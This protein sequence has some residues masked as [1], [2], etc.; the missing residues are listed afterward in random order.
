MIKRY[1]LIILLAFGLLLLSSCTRSSVEDPDMDGGAGFR[2]QISGTANPSV[3][4]IPETLP[5]VYSDITARVLNNDGSPAVNYT[6][7][8][9]TDSYGYFENYKISDTRTTDGGGNAR[10]RFFIP[11]GTRS[12]DTSID[13]KATVVDDGRNDIPLLSEIY[14]YIPI[15]IVPYDGMEMVVVRGHVYVCSGALGLPGVVLTFSN[16][17]G[18]AVSRNSG[19]Y[20]IYV[21]W[22]WTGEIK[23]ES[24][25]FSFSP[26]VITV[27]TPLYEDLSGQDFF[28]TA[29]T[30]GLVANPTSFEIGAG[31]ASNLEVWVGSADNI[32]P[33]SY[34]V[35][36]GADWITIAAGEDTGTTADT[37]HFN[38]AA[39]GSGD[40]RSAEISVISTTAGIISELTIAVSQDG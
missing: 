39:N 30:Y 9:Q 11:P 40:K 34:R 19:S 6:V 10:I 27:L 23:P 4:Y 17:G 7:I 2:V 38:V 15:R 18:L 21:P 22:G 31:G 20:D 14:D 13:L 24:E 12:G 16:G 26:D 29:S 3:L 37:F 35:T 28:G 8:F 5:S 36:P 1:G 33:I 32:C 25:G